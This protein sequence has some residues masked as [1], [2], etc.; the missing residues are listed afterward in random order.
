MVN[1]MLK[2][3]VLFFNGRLLPPSETFIRAQGEGLERY[4]PYYVGS[5]QVNGLPLPEDRTFVV[6]TGGPLG[7]AK[8]FVF[9]QYGFA[10]GFYKDLA[11]LKPAFLHAHFGICGALALPLVRVLKIPMV[12]TAYGIDVTMKDELARKASLSHR[13]YFQRLEQLK[14]TPCIIIAIS[15]FIKSKL[16]EKGFPENKILIHR[17]GVDTQIFQSDP[18]VERKPVV[19]FVGRLV[20]KKGC[21]YLIR[22]MAKVQ[23]SRPDIELV[24]IGDGP[25]RNDLETLAA[26]QLRK[27]RFLGV[28]PP[29]MVKQWMSQATIFSVPSITAESGDTEGLGVVFA[30]AQA[31][32]TP[33]VSSL[34]GGIPE[35]VFDGNTGF[36][37]AEKDWESLARHITILLDDPELW[38]RF[39]IA[40][41]QRI[42]KMYDQTQLCREQEEIYDLVM[43]KYVA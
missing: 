13:V 4:V 35:V 34:S 21:E 27:Y 33:V 10:P 37:A 5:K 12:L 26:G 20:E 22:A 36:L 39:S 3:N 14:Q 2:K 19:L 24:L 16:L 9:K 29:E 42:Q 43:S 40:G 30:E 15:E 41:Q 6:N 7:L 1:T 8:E 25:L 18:S 11:T 38:Q 32:G 23:A 28:Q 31:M 17:I